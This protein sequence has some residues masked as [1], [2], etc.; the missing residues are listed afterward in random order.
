MERAHMTDDLISVDQKIPDWLAKSIFLGEAETIIRSGIKFKLG[1]MGF[2]TS[3]TM[4][5][6]WFSL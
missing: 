5:G 3:D 4:W 2:S 1:I 6:L